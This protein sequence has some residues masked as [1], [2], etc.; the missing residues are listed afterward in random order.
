MA[1]WLAIRKPVTGLRSTL[2]KF[3]AFLLPL[4]MW[5]AVSYCPFVW[6]PLVQVTEPGD[7]GFDVGMTCEPRVFADINKSLLADG[8][9]P[10]VAVPAN[11]KYLPPPHRVARALYTAFTTEPYLKGDPWLHESLVRSLQVIFFGFAGAMLLAI[12]IGIVCGTFDA[13]SKIVEPFVDFVRYMPPPSFGALMMAIWGL[14]DAPKVAIIFIGCFFNMVLVTAN[15]ARNLDGSLLEAAQ[16]LGAKRFGL[17]MHVIVPGILPGILKDVRICLGAAWTFL[18]A[19]ELIGN[20]SGLSEFINQQQKHQNYDNVYAGVL[21]IGIMGFVIDQI[22]AFIGSVIFPWTPDAN[23]RARRWFRWLGFITQPVEGSRPE[24]LRPEEIAGLR[25][26][27]PSA[28]ASGAEP[29]IA[30]PA[31]KELTHA[32]R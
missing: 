14:F 32:E 1:T 26:A 18:T 24:P 21:M 27:V 15:T 8:K 9:K 12:P 16:T 17:M 11:P 2:L 31:I 3:L 10:C 5:C 13:A 29:P 30:I 7:S 28:E 6:H 4:A 19:A 25:R 20:M 23:H 22:L